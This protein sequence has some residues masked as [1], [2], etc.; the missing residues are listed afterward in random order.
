MPVSE[1][2]FS[3]K[4]YCPEEEQ[5]ASKLAI[6]KHDPRPVTQRL[7]LMTKESAPKIDELGNEKHF[8]RARRVNL[9]SFFSGKRP[10][11]SKN[12]VV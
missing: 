8:V 9:Y 5:I 4:S 1:A 3:Y 6:L 11:R 7:N 10:V 12:Q 2:P